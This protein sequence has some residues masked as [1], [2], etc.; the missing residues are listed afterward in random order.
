MHLVSFTSAAGPSWGVLEDAEIADLGTGAP[1]AARTLGDALRAGLLDSRLAGRGEA[2]RVRL[3]SVTLLP[4]VT[5]AEKIICVGLNYADHVREMHRPMP[6]KPVI[7]T[8]WNDTF[9]GAGE[10]LVAPSVS[11]HFDYEGELAV[12]L[13]KPAYRVTPEEAAACVLGYSLI[14]DGS[15]RD[16]QR[17][18]HQFAPGKNFPRSGSFGP[19]IVTPDEVGPFDGLRI[20]TRLNG[21]TVQSSTLDELIFSVPELISYCSQWTPLA[22][23]DVIATGTPGGVG[24]SYDPPKWMRAGDTVEVEIERVGRL[25]NPVVAEAGRTDAPA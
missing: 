8:R 24:D 19:S 5:D 1:A 15:L 23:G 13:G 11:D 21:E 14:N 20:S 4:P 17:H 2:P 6:E 3:D 22:P 12:V 16:F 9:V 25:V 18:T 7:F 10:A